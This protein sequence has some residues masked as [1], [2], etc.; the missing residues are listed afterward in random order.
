[1]RGGA[2]RRLQPNELGACDVP[3]YVVARPSGKGKVTTQSPIVRGPAGQSQSWGKSCDL[4]VF[5]N[6][7][8]IGQILGRGHCFY[9]FVRRRIRVSHF[10][11]ICRRRKA[12]F[13]S[14]AILRYLRYQSVVV[15]RSRDFLFHHGRFLFRFGPHCGDCS[16]SVS[17]VNSG[18]RAHNPPRST[19]FW[20]QD[21]EVLVN[22]CHSESD[23]TDGN[24]SSPMTTH[25][26]AATLS[27]S[28]R[29]SCVNSQF[30]K[31]TRRPAKGQRRL[32]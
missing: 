27:M 17:T 2:Q 26:E 11:S 16:Y 25:K 1:M 21:R 3:P 8:R 14:S 12:S 31:S 7:P 22:C 10:R 32:K 19:R 20:W 23:S 15:Q 18:I 6:M 28:A 13:A 24:G 29:V 9:Q 5:A 30:P 4:L